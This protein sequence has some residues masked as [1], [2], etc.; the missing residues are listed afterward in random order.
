MIW[1]IVR[2]LG[3]IVLTLWT[4]FTISLRFGSSTRVAQA[5]RLNSTGAASAWAIQRHAD[6]KVKI[7]NL[8]RREITL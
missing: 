1:F 6:I 4:V 8:F 3:W 7:A 5:S 2:R